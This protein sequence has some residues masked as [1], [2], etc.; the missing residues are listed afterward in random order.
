MA[1]TL[2]RPK[3][4][5]S[6]LR[7]A[8]ALAALSAVPILAQPAP[9]T[10]DALGRVFDASRPGAVY[11]IPAS[12]GLPGACGGAGTL[13]DPLRLGDGRGGTVELFAV[14]ED[15][16]YRGYLRRGSGDSELRLGE[17]WP[18]ELAACAPERSAAPASVDPEPLDAGRAR[19]AAPRGCTV[20]ELPV[21]SERTGSWGASC[22]SSHRTGSLARFYTVRLAAR[23][24]LRLAATAAE[25]ATLYLLRPR[26]YAGAP[27]AT[28][29]PLDDPAPRLTAVVPAGTWLVEIASHGSHDPGSYALRLDA[30]AVGAPAPFALVAPAAEA[31]GVAAE[32]TLTWQRSARAKSYQVRFGTVDPPPPIGAP[33]KTLSYRPATAV[34]PLAPGTRYFWLVEARNAVGTTAAAGGVR[35]F[36]TAPAAVPPGRF[37][38]LVPAAGET[39]VALAPTLAWEAAAGATSY[40]VRLGTTNPPPP[41][42]EAVVAEPRLEV[43]PRFGA[44]ALRTT[45]F[46]T[47]TARNAWGETVAVDAPR[48]FT[49]GDG[50]AAP[51]PFALLAPAAGATGVAT[52]PTLG[53]EPSA[54]ATSYRVHF[55]T[56]DPP[57]PANDRVVTARE[58]RP[59]VAYGAALLP[60]TTY[61]WWVEAENGSGRTANS[62]GSRRFT[63]ASSTG[64]PGAFALTAPADGARDVATAPT[65]AWQP[66]PGAT[67]YR[68]RF[69]TTDP[70][71]ASSEQTTT[72]TTFAPAAVFGTLGKGVTYFWTVVAHN[73]A[74]DTAA[75]AVW[76]FTT[77]GGA[78]T[79]PGACALQ[80]PAAGATGVS[81]TPTLSWTAASGAT[82]Y[83]VS[84]GTANPPGYLAEVAGTTFQ[85][86]AV[87]GTLPARTIHYWSV[88]ARNAAGSTVCGTGARA[89]STGDR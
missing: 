66:S 39:G 53:W 35:S 56:S 68:V 78:V 86:A 64:V 40:A 85:P 12:G 6:V 28:S 74:G 1:S 58:F 71:P 30:T 22:R 77:A 10:V 25:G 82:S 57:P 63:T 55:G 4:I 65:L 73:D 19:A 20:G 46:W 52:A 2:L 8:L 72:A 76:S 51:G 15:G 24:E 60:G 21:G 44:L 62:G 26:A 69:G 80:S 41:G 42:D 17:A 67:S 7:R 16:A 70:P 32:P 13:D 59:A 29:A 34:G 50:D 43:A 37:A 75:G 31:T 61:T 89:F 5:P 14:T 54:G 81:R 83:V 11:E 87:L 45:Y 47:V 23:S 38:L 48:S 27:V 33:V 84:L 3:R 36:V 88:E 9:V 79:P 18:G 49:T